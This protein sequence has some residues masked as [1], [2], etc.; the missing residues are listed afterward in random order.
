VPRT[1][2]VLLAFA[3]WM[4]A[5]AVGETPQGSSAGA[6]PQYYVSF[7]RGKA[8]PGVTGSPVL[9]LPFQCTSDG[10]VFVSFVSTAPSN[11][12]LP[13]P[14]PGVAPM[15]LTAIPR[16]GAGRTF[17]IDQVP[18]LYVSGERDHSA[19]DSGVALLVM[20]SRENKP[21]KNAY[22]VGDYNGETTRNS[23][24][25]HKYLLTFSRDGE[26]RRATELSEGF[27]IQEIGVFPSGELLAFGLDEKD[28]S[29]KLAV[30]KEDGTLLKFLELSKGEA[31]RSMISGAEGPHP[32]SVA[33]AELVAVGH[34]I[35]LVQNRSR[36]PLLEVTEGG[37]IRTIR[38]KLPEGEQVQALIPSD[39]DLYV[40]AGPG[41]QKETK[42]LIYEI[43]PGDGAV[44]KRFSLSDGGRASDS[45]ACVNDGK[46]LSIE[47]GE[48]EVIPLIGSPEPVASAEE[49]KR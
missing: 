6:V 7:A 1:G 31:P 22:T 21:S 49:P 10:T 32:H 18:E 3:T 29:P 43:S 42:Q 11:A 34:S 13:P 37:A 26:F 41:G 40:I 12:G 24:E 25:Q 46:F 8:V 19:Y 17:R 28:N 30:L 48:G 38:P 23:A 36:Y 45:V 14:P 15:V 2:A 47:Y 27:D 39:H 16:E 44:V 33:P 9:K 4:L 5:F 35:I 20:A